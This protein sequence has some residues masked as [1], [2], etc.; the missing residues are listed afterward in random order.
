MALLEGMGV[1]PVTANGS[2]SGMP[3]I[4]GVLLLVAGIGAVIIG[5]GITLLAVGF[6]GGPSALI[7]ALALAFG[8]AQ[9]AASIGIKNGR[10]WA[11]PLGIGLAAIAA[12]ASLVGL[13]TAVTTPPSPFDDPGVRRFVLPIIPLAAYGFIL[14]ALLAGRRSRD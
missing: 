7:G 13:V 10:S 8:A 9:I 6:P 3:L 4:A 5:L 14:W 1:D 2:R 11:A 12:L